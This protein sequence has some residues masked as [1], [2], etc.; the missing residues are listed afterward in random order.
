LERQ[1]SSAY[2]GSMAA[3]Q[4]AT[5]GQCTVY[6]YGNYRFRPGNR[7]GL[8]GPVPSPLANCA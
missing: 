8:I 4:G 6:L 1:W 7:A 3:Y 2:G 5:A